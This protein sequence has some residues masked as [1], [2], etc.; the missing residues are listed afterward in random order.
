VKGFRGKLTTEVIEYHRGRIKNE[1]FEE[2]AL[3][4][5]VRPQIVPHV[6]CG[7]GAHACVA[8]DTR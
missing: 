3:T 4:P 2:A 1:H 7:T 6:C 8:A 5:A